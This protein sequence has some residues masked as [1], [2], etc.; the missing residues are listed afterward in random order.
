MSAL[1]P[2]SRSDPDPLPEG[3][4]RPV[5]PPSEWFRPRYLTGV[6]EE[7][8]DVLPNQRKVLDL[9]LHLSPS[10]YGST[11]SHEGSPCDIDT[12]GGGLAGGL[13]M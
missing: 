8:R 12:K 6:S 3:L 5:G 13:F 4:V 2:Q 11:L 9:R 7:I 10:P 1:E